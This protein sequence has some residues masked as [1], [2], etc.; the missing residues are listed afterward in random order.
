[1]KTSKFGKITFIHGP[2]RGRYPGCNSIFIDDGEGAVIDPGSSERFLLKIR[3]KARFLFNSHYH[4]DHTAFNHLFPE[5]LL[6]VHREESC[7]YRSIR[8]V[9]D[10]YGL[11]GSEFEGLWRDILIE[12]FHY[13]ERTPDG[14]FLDGDVF[15]VG[16]TRMEVI[17]TPGHSP[18][19]SSFWFPGE[20]VLFLGDLDM[21][22]FGPWYGDRVS[23]IDQTID[24]VRKIL[25]VPAE[26]FL[27][28]HESEII[29]K[30]DIF[31]QAEAYL[32]IIE[33][34]EGK[35]LDYLAEPRGLD[36][37]VEQWFIYRKPREPRHFFLF[38]ERA[39]TGKHLERLVRN[40]KIR[41]E[42]GKYIR[43]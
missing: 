40:G 24:S 13:R 9:L 1:M 27:S 23:D 21:T 32:D 8:N 4:E 38:G 12:R 25:E 20:K 19:H 18:G 14:E 31:P 26:I 22:P 2:D 36:E 28:G 11:L 33:K 16:G 3:D 7:C 5:A 6:Y 17:H 43:N 15:I 34:R 29:E 39:L 37:I 41:L 30:E 35:I 10:Y 42:K